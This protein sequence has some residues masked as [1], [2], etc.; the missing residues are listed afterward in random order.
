MGS[1]M[2]LFIFL[3]NNYIY[4]LIYVNV[5]TIFE[6]RIVVIMLNR[7]R[8]H[9]LHCSSWSVILVY[10]YLHKYFYV[11]SCTY[12]SIS[13]NWKTNQSTFWPACNKTEVYMTVQLPKSSKVNLVNFTTWPENGRSLIPT[14]CSQLVNSLQTD[15]E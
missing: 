14:A 5:K 6:Y 10:L 12:T 2:H 3:S 15:H 1:N 13:Q 9:I 4:F 11:P 7:E 8:C